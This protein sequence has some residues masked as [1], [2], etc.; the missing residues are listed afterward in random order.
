MSLTLLS[1]LLFG[2]VVISLVF[3]SNS[4]SLR[5]MSR[6]VMSFSDMNLGLITKLLNHAW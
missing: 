5:V 2:M 6:G 1:L 3:S 4:T